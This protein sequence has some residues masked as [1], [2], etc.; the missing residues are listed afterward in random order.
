MQTKTLALLAALMP[1]ALADFKVFCGQ[2][3][4]VADA[5]GCGPSCIFMNNPASCE[6]VENSVNFHTQDD[7]SKCDGLRCEGCDD[8]IPPRDWFITELEIND[9]GQCTPSH[10]SFDGI[11]N[12]HFTLYND[13]TNVNILDLDGNNVGTCQVNSDPQVV[14]CVN[15]VGNSGL[16]NQFDCFSDLYYIDSAN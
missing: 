15:P 9:R 10:Q 5:G 6:D 7:V 1:A 3:C 14:D 4:V 8:G 2:R 16:I 11:E 13:G 12:R